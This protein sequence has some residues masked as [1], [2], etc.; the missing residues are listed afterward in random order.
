MI[1]FVLALNA[2]YMK[3][4]QRKVSCPY[5]EGE[6]MNEEGSKENFLPMNREE[7]DNEVE[8]FRMRLE[9]QK[10]FPVKFRPLVSEEFLDKLRR[11]LGSKLDN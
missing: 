1:R 8:D 10:P 3:I 7:A 9:L 6:K 5:E 4:Y 2:K 11:E